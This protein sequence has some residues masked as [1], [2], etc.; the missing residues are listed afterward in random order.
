MHDLISDVVSNSLECNMSKINATDDNAM[1]KL[2]RKRERLEA[3][4][5]FTWISV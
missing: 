2:T 3:K 5:I 4:N 1:Y